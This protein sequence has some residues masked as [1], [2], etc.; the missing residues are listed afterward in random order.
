MLTNRYS[1]RDS[2]LQRNVHIVNGSIPVSVQL[3]TIWFKTKTLPGPMKAFFSRPRFWRDEHRMCSIVFIK[4]RSCIC[5][6]S[7]NFITTPNTT[8]RKTI[9]TILVVLTDST[10]NNNKTLT[11]R[12]ECLLFPGHLLP[13][14]KS[15][16]ICHIMRGRYESASTIGCLERT[17]MQLATLKY[18]QAFGI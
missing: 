9:S 18:V 5:H 2:G 4:G 6:W 17:R 3:L 12:A 10:E 11:H 16:W 1:S 15:L 14:P 8:E 13:V 7:K